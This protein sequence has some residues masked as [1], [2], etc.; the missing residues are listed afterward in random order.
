MRRRAPGEV[1]SSIQLDHGD[2]LVMDGPAQ[3]ECEHC[4]ASGL[5]GPRVHLTYRH[6]QAWWVAFSQRVCNV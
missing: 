5:Q 3:S 4:T 2:V 1:P 6:L